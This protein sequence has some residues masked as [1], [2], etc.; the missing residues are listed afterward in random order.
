MNK[1]LNVGQSALLGL[2]ALSVLAATPAMA[3]PD[4]PYGY[5][6]SSRT[7]GWQG[8]RGGG[9]IPTHGAFPGYSPSEGWQGAHERHTPDMTG[10]VPWSGSRMTFSPTEGYQG[11]HPQPTTEIVQPITD[12][13]R[14][15]AQK[16]LL[17]IGGNL[18]QLWQNYVAAIL[19]H[20]E[21]IGEIVKLSA[22]NFSSPAEH[23]NLHRELMQTMLAHGEK[24]N[25][26]Y[27]GLLSKLEENK[28]AILKRSYEQVLFQHQQMEAFLKG[29]L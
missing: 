11:I 12:E 13:A 20:N 3:G 29:T 24:L 15:R 22:T 19:T 27:E 25:A 17:G 2:A 9:S 5:L 21:M 18:E 26:A 7:E 23:A 4:D 28:K 6:R 16:S 14:L 8:A 10:M 1:R